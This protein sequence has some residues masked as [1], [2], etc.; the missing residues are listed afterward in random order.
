MGF[1]CSLLLI[2]EREEGVSLTQRVLEN[3]L[4]SRLLDNGLFYPSQLC[5]VSCL[6]IALQ[7]RIL[8][9]TFCQSVGSR[10]AT[11]LIISLNPGVCVG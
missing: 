4:K 10:K 7:V 8:S 9:H 5:N 3:I 2:K 6:N 1:I 11:G